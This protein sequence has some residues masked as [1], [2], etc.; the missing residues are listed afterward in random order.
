MSK[1]SVVEEVLRDLYDRN[2]QLTPAL[3]VTEAEAETHPL[4]AFF[5]WD[6]A[7]AGH[8]HRLNE[9]RQLIRTV[10]VRFVDAN[11]NEHD[12]RVWH[13]SHSTGDS[14]RQGY[15]P[16]EEVRASPVARTILLST[17]EREWRSLRRRYQ[18]I[19]EF[20]TMVGSDSSEVGEKAS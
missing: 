17:M 19:Q 3:V 10:K 9:A 1:Q 13:A 2:G 15:V 18:H 20:W 11:D 7:Q 5:T 16:D 12:I 14:E 4:H 8:K 6:D